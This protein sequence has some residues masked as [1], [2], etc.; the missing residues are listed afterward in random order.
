MWSN[1]V[2]R[3]GALATWD[4]VCWTLGV[5]FVIGLRYSFN[6]NEVQ[7][8]SVLRY[9]VL[10]CVL[11]V[12]IGVATKF[13]RGRFLVGS[14]D[15]A[16]GLALHFLAVAAI[17]VVTAPV[18][19]DLLP[20]SLPVLAPPMALV[21][22]AAGR[23]FYRAMRDRGHESRH[24]GRALLIYGAGDAGRQVLSLVRA[25]DSLGL[26]P[27]GFLDDNPGK[28]HLRIH[29]IPVVGSGASLVE[30]ADSVD[31]SAVL[32]AVPRA[33][34]ELVDR[35]QRQATKAGL[36]VLVLPRLGELSN[37]EVKR[38]DIRRVE[39]SDVLGRH[40]VATDLSAI[41]GYLSGKR[42]LITGAGG[43]IGSEL[44][45][46]VHRFGP[47]SMTLLDRD[48]SALHAVQL[49]I[50]G[51]GLLDSPETVLADIREK[52][53]LRAIFADVRPQIVFHAAALKHLP[54]LER[55]P[56]EGWKT[57]VLGT[58]NLLQLAADFDVERFVNIS[59]DK[60]ADAT[61]VLGSTKRLAEQLTAWHAETT[62]APFMSVR[63]G[64]VL[65]SRGSMLH[66]FNAQ[67]AGGGPITVTHPDVTRYF[68]TIPE[69]CELVVQAGAMGDG[70]AVMVLEMGEPV[71]I[72][73]V[74]KRMISLSGPRAST[75]S[76]VV[77]VRARSYMRS[78]SP[79]RRP[80][81]LPVTR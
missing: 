21:A 6:I 1:S 15:E 50:Y 60:A 44:A 41:A 78:S 10:S 63:F 11:L 73:D 3:R 9:L 57:N 74:A 17:T 75:S 76:S 77:C 64:N 35:V 40:Q 26:R 52:D 20:R 58:L 13:Y 38:N 66:T 30:A 61:S 28:R 81:R 16:L 49:A 62:G 4:V 69:A 5:A 68:M 14:F 25:D 46:Q 37:G 45:R 31:A 19:N 53:S 18:L 29:G 67:I 36:E 59:T 56:A 8:E 34:G 79:R 33:P 51:H 32:I 72:L 39:I 24:S 42:V 43:S 54:M 27:V 2:V 70:G 65:G 22:A 12:V 23:W 7:W 55:F 47:S 80:P 48:E 71:R